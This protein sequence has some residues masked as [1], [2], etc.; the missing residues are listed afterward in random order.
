MNTLQNPPELRIADIQYLPHHCCPTCMTPARTTENGV[1]FT[2][3]QDWFGSPLRYWQDHLG[4][5]YFRCSCQHHPE[6]PE[7]LR[8]ARLGDAILPVHFVPWNAPLNAQ[9]IQQAVQFLAA[10]ADPAF[11]AGS[12]WLAHT[13]YALAAGGLSPAAARRQ[14]EMWLN[15]QVRMALEETPDSLS[16]AELVNL[17]I[18]G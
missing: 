11:T 9:R 5:V 16:P 10:N 3:Y 4:Y 6:L 15:R 7:G 8:V 2:P 1:W 13:L 12:D 14:L 17:E 18:S